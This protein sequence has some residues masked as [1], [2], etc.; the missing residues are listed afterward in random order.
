MGEAT[1]VLSDDFFSEEYVNQSKAW[2]RLVSLSAKHPNI[3]IEEDEVVM[4]R[5]SQCTIKFDDRLI[6]G[7]HCRVYREVSLQSKSQIIFVQDLRFEN[8]C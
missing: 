7:K 8:V 4:G 1:Q 2:G 6:S 3:D 5:Q